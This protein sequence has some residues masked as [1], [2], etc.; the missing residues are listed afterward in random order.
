MSEGF[1]TFRE[2]LEAALVVGILSRYVSRKEQMWLWGGIAAAIGSSLLAAFLL[3]RLSIV[4]QMWEIVFS[5]LAAAMLIYMIVWMRRHSATLSE[6]LRAAAQS[7]TG[8]LLFSLSFTT[9]LREGLETALFLRTLWAMQR[10]ISWI[11]GLFGLLMAAAVGVLIFVYGRRVPLRPFFNITSVLLL[12]VA[13]GMASYAAHELIELLEPRYSWAEELAEYKAW[14]LFAPQTEVPSA[15]SWSY[16]FY[17]GKYYP[18][19]HH[20]GWIG[21][22]LH[23]LTGWRASVTWAELGVWLASLLGGLFLWHKNRPNR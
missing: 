19:L 16:T 9:V 20:K 15:Y 21:A 2:A 6:E 10:D 17:D 7:S 12:M 4:H 13:A 18:L 22:F 3:V 5:G 14:N 11:G 8:W 23:L 1:V